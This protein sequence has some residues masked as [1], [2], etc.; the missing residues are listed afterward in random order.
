[1]ARLTQAHDVYRWICGGVQVNRHTLS[2]FRVA[3]A[4]ALDD[5]LTD[6]VASLMAARV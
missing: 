4:R 5:L 3:H 1:V 2:Y 6:S